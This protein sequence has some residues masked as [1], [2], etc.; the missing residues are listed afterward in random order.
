MSKVLQRATAVLA[1]MMA[2]LVVVATASAQMP[3]SPW[4]NGRTVPGAG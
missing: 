4:K 1:V 2:S 3:T